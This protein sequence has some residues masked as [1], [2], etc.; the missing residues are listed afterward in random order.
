MFD[1]KHYV[2]ILKGRK[3]EY[4]ALETLS[5]AV[6]NAL[7]P[8]IEIPPIPWDWQ[9]EQ[10]AKSIGSHLEKVGVNLQRCWPSDRPL[11]LDLLWI[12]ESERMSDGGHPLEY[13]F[14]TAR[15]RSL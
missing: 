5:P 1:H 2:P 9:E 3:G 12:S 15:E 8:L 6:K 4:G 10:P 7:T 13:V 14:R 11:C